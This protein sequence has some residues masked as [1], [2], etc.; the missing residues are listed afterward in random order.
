VEVA[1]QRWWSEGWRELP[2]ERTRSRAVQARRLNLQ[3]GMDLDEFA[4]AMEARGWQRAEAANWR[5][6]VQA[7]NPDPDEASLPMIHKD[8]LGRPDVLILRQPDN[9]DSTQVTIRVWESG[10]VLQP[11][12]TPLYLGQVSRETLVQRLRLFSY[13]RAQPLDDAEFNAFRDGLRE[14]GAREPEDRLLLLR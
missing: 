6:L 8:Y 9:D 2:R 12:G 7:L 11:H 13:W 5:W 4:S 10:Q 14:L 1:E 3:V